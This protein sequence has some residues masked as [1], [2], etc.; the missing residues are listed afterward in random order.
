MTMKHISRW[1]L[2]LCLAVGAYTAQAV[3]QVDIEHDTSGVRLGYWTSDFDAAKALADKDHIPMIGFWGSEGCGYCAKM[4]STALL[5]DEFLSWVETHK[6]VMCFV[7]VPA[8]KTRIDTP[9]KTFMKGGNKSGEWPYMTFYWN[10]ADGTEVKVDFTGR[11]GDIP[12][13]AKGTTGAQLVTGLDTYFAGYKPVDAYTGGYFLVTNNTATARME[14]LVGQTSVNVPLTR[15]STAAGANKLQV[16]TGALTAVTWAA[17]VTEQVVKCTLPANLAAGAKVNL[18]LYTSDGKTVKSQAVVNIVSEP[19]V[20][21]DNPRWIG[22]PFRVGEWTMDLDAALAQGKSSAK[23]YTL[24]YAAGELWCPWCGDLQTR[25]IKSAAFTSW[26]RQNN[27]NLVLL[28]NPKRSSSDTKDADGNVTSVGT[29]A[30]GAPPTLLRYAVGSNGKSG[31]AYMMRKNIAVGTPTT[32]NTAEYVLQ[33]NH[34]IL[35]KGGKLCAPEAMRTGY[36]TFILVNPD[37]T[38]AGQ[39]LDA[40]ADDRTWGISV[41]ETL[42]RLTELLKLAGGNAKDSAPSTTTQ[43]LSVEDTG[44]GDGQVNANTTFFKLAN[45]PAGKVTFEATG[46]DA[47]QRK[48]SPV[49]TVYETSSTRAK[50]KTLATGTGKVTVTFANGANKYLAVSHYTDSLAAYGLR[51]DYSFSVSSTVTLVPSQ[52]AATFTTRTGRVNMT[53]TKDTRYKLS[54]FSSY[55]D[56]TKNADG[57]YTAKKSGTLAMSAAKGAKLAFQIWTPG[58][59]QFTTTSA[60]KLEA[61]GSGTVLVA[62]TG[63]ASGTASVTVSVNKGS[64]GS[65]RVSVSPTTLTWADGA[66]GSKTVT[67][68]IAANTEFN[69]DEVFT[70]TLAKA[71]SSAAVL[72]ANKT[73]TLKVSDTDDPVLPSARY[74]VR[75][76]SGLGANYSYAVSNI[77]ENK[78]VALNRS[79]TLPAGLSLTYDSSRK[80]VVLSGTPRRVGTYTFT[81]SVTENRSAKSVTGSATTFT[82]TVVDAKSLKPGEQGYNPVIAAGKTFYGSIPLYGKL[83]GNTV[84]AGVATLTAYSTGRVRVAY[85]GVDGAR[86]NFTGL[87]ALDSEGTATATAARFGVT[88]TLKVDAKG[89][90]TARITGL[91][92]RYGTTLTSGTAGYNLINTNYGAYAGYYTVTLPVNTAEL[93][94][95]KETI[96]TGTGYVILKMNTSIFK[97]GGKVSYVGMLANGKTFNGSAYLSGTMATRDGEEW[98]CLPVVVSKNGAGVGAVLRIR[99]NAAKTYTADPQVVLAAAG[100]VPFAYFGDDYASVTVYG[101]IYDRTLDFSKCCEDFYETTTFQFNSET[102]YFAP[103]DQYGSIKTLPRTQVTVRADGSFV[104]SNADAQHAVTLK[105]AKATGIV[106]G[107][108][109]VT[110]SGGRRLSLKIRGVVLF[111]WVDCGCSD[112]APSIER[113]IFSGASYY[114]DRINGAAAVRGFEVDLKP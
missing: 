57:T 81:V 21:V 58:V 53:V 32:K 17:N 84:L 94:V 107:R 49:L 90:A 89:L 29:K 12:P 34:D 95:G 26:A 15:T 7:E 13:Y 1:I 10:K 48:I 77:R 43:K 67:Y 78:S 56:F 14:A 24:A 16:G 68:K 36:P 47:S 113:P 51:T 11:K 114:N 85:T 44:D 9:A 88:M 6:I 23:T 109:F 62:R 65:G 50:A 82:V 91:G 46:Y 111:G 104:V 59:V 112:V 30:D 39:M 87:F 4:K 105:L 83:N 71:A 110:F 60:S 38:A 72:G 108:M 8:D 54:G 19:A 64:N 37:G 35:Y 33:R 40:C 28:D 106:T 73:F 66:S 22:E 80:A 52:T 86:G 74:S 31:A 99:K 76:Y 18:K 75:C 101:G 63:G 3:V 98:A 93:T 70:I 5:S 42:N 27:V 61:D 41:D 97:R 2:P 25:V 96:P 100:S 45:V 92:G 55:A 103:S 79:G 69:P 20:S 102:R